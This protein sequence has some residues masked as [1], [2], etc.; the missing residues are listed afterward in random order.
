MFFY[1]T[2]SCENRTGNFAEGFTITQ[3]PGANKSHNRNFEINC[4]VWN[5]KDKKTLVGGLQ[6]FIWP[7]LPS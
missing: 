6:S 2:V 3:L 1:M 4:Y 7:N 5:T